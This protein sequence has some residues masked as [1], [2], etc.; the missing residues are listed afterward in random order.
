MF[1]FEE[2]LQLEMA[3]FELLSANTPVLDAEYIIELAMVFWELFMSPSPTASYCEVN[4]ESV[5]VLL[6]LCS[7]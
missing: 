5:I 2:M 6:G 7:R 1:E 3:L 4:A